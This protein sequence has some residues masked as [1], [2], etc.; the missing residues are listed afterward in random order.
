[1]EQC[2][3]GHI[4][5]CHRRFKKLEVKTSNEVGIRLKFNRKIC[6]DCGEWLGD[7][8]LRRAE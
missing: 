6:A 4:H 7:E 5:C 3:C 2:K 1:M 8:D